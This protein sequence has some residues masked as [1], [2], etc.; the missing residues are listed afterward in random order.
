MDLRVCVPP[1]LGWQYEMG[2]AA[3]CGFWL[4]PD[5]AEEGKVKQRD[6]EEGTRPSL[7]SK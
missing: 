2:Q 1:A 6:N 5:K 7:I 4:Q 3:V